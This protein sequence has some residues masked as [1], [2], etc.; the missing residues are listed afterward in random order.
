MAI[1]AF[2]FRFGDHNNTKRSEKIPTMSEYN[3]K[4]PSSLLLSLLGEGRGPGPLL[5]DVLNQILEAQVSEHPGAE[6]YERN[7][8]RAGYRNG[9]RPRAN[10]RNYKAMICCM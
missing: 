3:I 4:V 2:L 5:K 9:L 8:E 6:R 7:S 1:V 10:A